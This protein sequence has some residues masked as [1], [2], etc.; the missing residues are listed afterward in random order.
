MAMLN[1]YNY[2][3]PKNAMKIKHGNKKHIHAVK[4]E[5][6]SKKDQYLEQKIMAARPEQLTLMLYDGMVRF[7][8]QGKLFMNG[9][10]DSYQKVNNSLQRAQAIMNELRSTLDMDIDISEN[11]DALYDYMVRRTVE[12]NID[13]DQEILDEVVGLAE[14]L[15]DTWQEAM[16]KI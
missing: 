9:G 12:A 15:R 16:T 4:N 5:T 13:K 3:K 8:K 7:L 11:L 1:P 6:T 10:K 14:E 2:K